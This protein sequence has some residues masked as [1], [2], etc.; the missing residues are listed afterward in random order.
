MNDARLWALLLTLVSGLAGV[1]GGM[2]LADQMRAP[3]VDTGPFGDYERLL[4]DEFDLDSVRSRHLS[5]LLRNYRR[6]IVEVE[7]RH[8]STYRSALEPEL[9]RLG[10]RYHDLIR[11]HVLPAN[12]RPRF[13]ELAAGLPLHQ[14]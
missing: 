11:N 1:A 5:D 10:Q 13:D 2:L 8:L 12:R 4:V 3:A 6:D 7:Q 9:A 14:D